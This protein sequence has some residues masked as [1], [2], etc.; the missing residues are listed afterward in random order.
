LEVSNIVKEIRQITTGSLTYQIGTRNAATNLRLRDGETQ[1]LAGLISREERRSADRVP[2]LGELPVV[3]RLFSNTNETR[4]RTEVV[5]LIT[6]RLV[7]SLMR[8]DAGSVEFAAG[9]EAST[10]IPRLGAPLTPL[11]SDVVPQQ[12]PG[13]APQGATPDAPAEQ[14]A[15]PQQQP[16]A[17]PAGPLLVPFGGVKPAPQ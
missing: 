6:P 1:I 7:R 4:N 9:T 17:A 12:Q 3:G 10:G 5:L 8:P 13:A 14:G 11:P 16:G 2:G 15:A